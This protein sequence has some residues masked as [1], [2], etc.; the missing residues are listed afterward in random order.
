[1]LPAKV[2]KTGAE[3]RKSLIKGADTLAD[4]VKKTLGPS[5]R[6]VIY[7]TLR[8][9]IITNDGVSISKQIILDDEIENLG[10]KTLQEVSIKTSDVT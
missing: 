1:M 5:G 3:A 10:A 8:R 6:N 7:G 2:I 9:P 4:I